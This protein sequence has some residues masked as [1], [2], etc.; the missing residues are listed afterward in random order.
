MGHSV[1]AV[2]PSKEEKLESEQVEHMPDP[3]PLYVPAGQ[4]R[5]SEERVSQKVPPSHRVQLD[6]PGSEY[7]P[8]RQV[9]HEL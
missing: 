6:E 9:T 3:E 2:A 8:G 4:L 7:V 5:I 1:H